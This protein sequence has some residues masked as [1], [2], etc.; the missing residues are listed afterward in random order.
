MSFI[1]TLATNLK[2][3]VTYQVY[4]AVTDNSANQF[5]QEQKQ[6]RVVESPSDKPPKPTTPTDS[7]PDTFSGS[8]LIGKIGDQFVSITK[9]GFVPFIALILSMYV[10]NE[11]IMYS[12]PIRIVFFV[13]VFLICVIFTPF[14]FVLGMYYLGKAGYSY[15]LNKLSGGP[16]TKIMPTIFALLPLTTNIPTSSLGAFF[17]YPFTYPKTTKDAEQ[18]PIIMNNYME[19]LKS[20]FRYFD[21]V[22][23]LPF[24]A[25]EFTLLENSI[26]HLH[27]QTKPPA[28][29]ENPPLPAV[30][31][32][33]E[34]VS[35]ETPVN[36]EHLP[37]TIGS[38]KE[39]QM[40]QTQMEQTPLEQT[41]PPPKYNANTNLPPALP[42]KNRPPNY[43]PTPIPKQPAPRNLPPPPNNSKA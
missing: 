37:P 8:R 20:S 23:N 26:E 18:L 4:N 43:H 12:V 27:D 42:N 22:K 24:F 7:N 10:V 13:F 6:Q 31:E 3:K 33:S 36:V 41:P 2:N 30:I 17:M 35:V 32:K 11:M 19:S 14:L 21:T 5:A 29:V 1:N 28:E 9:K 34:N 40:E 38:L 16:K 25:D 15:Y 39:A